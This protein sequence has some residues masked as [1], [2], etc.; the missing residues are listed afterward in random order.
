MTTETYRSYT[1][2][3]TE[4]K[5]K[6]LSAEALANEREKTYALAL[7]WK[8]DRP[9]NSHYSNKLELID[10]IMEARKK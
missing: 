5:L 7:F 10:A 9:R 3:S 4:S 6:S 2:A 8:N 1:R